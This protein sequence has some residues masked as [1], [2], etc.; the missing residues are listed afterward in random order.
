VP[1]IPGLKTLIARH[2]GDDSWRTIRPPHLRLSETQCATLY[3]AFDA[4][5]VT[6]PAVA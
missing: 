3:A 4:C 2:A 1:L 6:L 5:G